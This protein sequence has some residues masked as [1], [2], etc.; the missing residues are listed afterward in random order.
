[1]SASR[2]PTLCII[3]YYCHSY[4]CSRG[5]HP[6]VHDHLAHK[7]N[8]VMCGHPFYAILL[9]GRSTQCR[10]GFD[11]S[12]KPRNSPQSGSPSGLKIEVVYELRIWDFSA[13]KDVPWKQANLAW[14]DQMPILKLSCLGYTTQYPQSLY[15]SFWANSASLWVA[16]GFCW[17]NYARLN[18]FVGG[19]SPM[20]IALH[21]QDAMAYPR[22]HLQA[23][24]LFAPPGNLKLKL[25]LPPGRDGWP[26]I[27]GSFNRSF[28]VNMRCSTMGVG[29]YPIFRQTQ[30]V[31][32]SLA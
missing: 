19:F 8:F 2:M 12:L 27:Y 15:Q 4:D 7:A 22:A 30:M 6:L 28:M 29:V 11:L 32:D 13:R 9:Y 10:L 16:S 1:M 31:L 14:Y 25:G 18:H 20:R 3:I 17:L 24:R 5:D 21:S 26:P 23:P